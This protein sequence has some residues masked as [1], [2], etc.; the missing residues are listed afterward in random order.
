MR[1][2]TLSF[3]VLRQW[4]AVFI[5]TSPAVTFAAPDRAAES[6][7]RT[8]VAL[9]GVLRVKEGNVLLSPWS[10]QNVLAMVYAGM[11]ADMVTQKETDAALHFG[12]DEIHPAVK[13]LGAAIVSGLPKEAELKT[14]NRLFPSVSCKLLPGFLEVVRGNYGAAVEPV[15]FAAPDKAAGMINAWVS[16]QTGGKIGEIIPKGALNAQTRLVLTNAVYF[17]IPWQVRFTKELT[18]EEPFW[19]STA[20][21]KTVPLM[22]KQ[23]QMRY[24]KKK[25]FQMAALPYSGGTL[26]L[27]VI[28]P[29]KRDGLA[30]V[31]KAL[32]PALLAECATM[33]KAEVRLSLPRFR[34]EPPAVELQ[35]ALAAIG[36][37]S[38]FSP[39]KA[40]FTRMTNEAVYISNIFHRT[41][42]DVN[43]DGTEAAAATAAAAKAANGHPH[44]TPHMIVRADHPFLF[45]IQHVSSGACLFLGRLA[46]PDLAKPASPVRRKAE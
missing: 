31:E 16:E 1:R 18:K 2:T 15:D 33:P 3:R 24:A 9:H 27:A 38:A 26:Q 40:N 43:E 20:A 10:I 7:N 21:Q 4:L 12:G 14:A 42:I 8:G 32:M 17:N 29:D 37:K 44:E 39:E 34:M 46:D 6:V 45:A 23:T 19:I 36:L 41:F 22:F 13:A 28:V 5:L 25:G 11:G 35:P 30:A